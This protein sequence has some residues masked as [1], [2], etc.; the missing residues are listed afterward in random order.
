MALKGTEKL[1]LIRELNAIRLSLPIQKGVDKL[2]SV[3]RINEIRVLLSIDSSSEKCLELDINDLEKSIES[4]RDYIKNGIDLMPKSLH[5]TEIETLI[6]VLFSLND[7]ETSKNAGIDFFGI[8]ED[9]KE[10]LSDENT[11]TDETALSHFSYFSR[12]IDFGHLA[13]A[14][15]FRVEQ[16]KTANEAAHETTPEILAKIKELDDLRDDLYTKTAGL[17]TKRRENA[18]TGNHVGYGESLVIDV[19]ALTS[20]QQEMEQALTEEYKSLMAKLHQANDEIQKLRNEKYIERDKTIELAKEKLKSIGEPIISDLLA[21]SPITQEQ[22]ETWANAQIIDKSSITRLQKQ[23]YKKE[24]VRKDMAEFYRI[25]G[26]KL[27]RIDIIANGSKRAN[28]GGIGQVEGVE[29]H[30]GSSFDK[31]VLWHELAHHLEADSAAKQASNDFLIKRRESDTVYSLSSLTGN[32]GYGRDEGAYKDSFIN[33]YVGKVYR[34]GTTEVFSMGVENLSDPVKLATMIAKDPEM[35]AMIIGYLKA[36][37]SPATKALQKL[38]NSKA[39]E[40]QAKREESKNEYQDAVDKLAAQVSITNDGWFDN[41]DD[42]SKKRLIS[43][44][45]HS[46]KDEKSKFVGSWGA[47]RV[48][49]GVFVSR[50]T[51]RKTKG[52]SVCFTDRVGTLKAGE[53]SYGYAAYFDPPFSMIGSD[54]TQVKAMI[55]IAKNEM[56]DDLSKVMYNLFVF[57]S[58]EQRQRDLIKYANKILGTPN[59]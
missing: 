39:G 36:D 13:N 6:K 56:H 22:A 58:E 31:R 11:Q 19:E 44:Y 25:S 3:K 40:N 29:I 16:I 33:E 46:L 52:F 1:I 48:F 49:S 51:K 20:Q 23:G 37:L 21:Q 18:G 4:M 47:Y 24:D 9:L 34:D 55:N 30:V 38:Q 17:V 2:K 35:A 43:G 54:L 45:Y 26:G 7:I 42:D 15:Y 10:K 59:E 5:K 32:R 41:L 28:A 14:A 12:D 50:K 8:Y 57:N 53:G 27:R